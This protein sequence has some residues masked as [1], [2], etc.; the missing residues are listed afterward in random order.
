MKIALLG[1]GKMG[2]EIEKVS[3]Q[4]KHDIVFIADVNN[5]DFRPDDLKEADAAIEF[6]TPG[7]AVSNILKCF[8]AQI[9]VVVGT[10]GW[11]E[12]FEEISKIC[13]SKE[14]ALFCST[15]FSIG[16][17]IFF[18]INKQL[19]SL[20]NPHAGYDVMIEELHHIQKL[21]APSGTAITLANDILSRLSRKRKWNSLAENDRKLK[22]SGG[23]NLQVLS[24]RKDKIPGTHIV[25]YES[26]IDSIEITHTAKNRI[27]F[28]TG[29]LLASEW[30]IGKKGVFGM[31][32]LLKL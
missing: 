18:E 20:M 28:A 29:A 19:A 14:Q 13:V 31:K 12:R 8:E 4:R 27:G 10:T 2:K 15:N 9:P 24:V 16:V 1:Y 25:E 22:K 30:I 32:D 11:Y 6:S 17:N 5:S 26:D 7:S 21:D 3:V 23:D